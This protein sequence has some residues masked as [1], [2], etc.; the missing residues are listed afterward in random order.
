MLRVACEP[1]AD[2]SDLAAI[3]CETSG[4]ASG[5]EWSRILDAASDMMAV[6]S[7]GAV[8]GVC[9]ATVTACR[10]CFCCCGA[11]ALCF[12]DPIPLVG[13]IVSIEGIWANGV[14]M[15]SSEYRV[16]NR[17]EVVRLDSDGGRI[18]WPSG[19]VRIT[20]SFGHAVDENT[21]FATA[22]LA[23][24]MAR[25]LKGGHC[26]IPKNVSSIVMNGVA[27]SK[28]EV[29]DIVREAGTDLPRVAAWMSMFN[30]ENERNKALVY[31]PEIFNG[32]TYTV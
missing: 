6:L 24:D 27:I 20:Y 23:A 29:A 8:T 4:L 2:E 7:G 12:R 15:A 32:W 1:F 14:A 28:R 10:E 9:S 5:Q 16:E 11:C 31:S 21:R 3:G 30:P 13:P 18:C 17:R 26:A 25:G 22:E 19:D